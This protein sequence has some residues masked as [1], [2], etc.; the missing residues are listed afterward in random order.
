MSCPGKCGRL[1]GCPDMHVRLMIRPEKPIGFVVVT[2][3]VFFI[4]IRLYGASVE[5]A[6]N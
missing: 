1:V 4:H 6:R 3:V 2:D 5:W